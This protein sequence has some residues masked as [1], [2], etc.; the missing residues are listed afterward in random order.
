MHC[1]YPLLLGLGLLM[2]GLGARTV[3]A[4]SRLDATFG[5]NGRVAVELGVKS[6]G[7]AVLVQP[8]GKIVV[9]G[10]SSGAKSGGMNFSLVRF[11][12]DGSL[13]TTFN[14]EGSAV[15]PLVAG[16][17]EALALGL[18]SDGR[19]VVGGYS[20]NGLDRDFALA[21]YR[22]DGVLDR[23][24]GVEG[25]VLTSI[26]NGNEEITALA[27]N[28][29][30]Q[31]TAVGSTEGTA[32]KALAVVRYRAD[33]SLDSSFGEQG[34]SLLGVGGDANAEGL[35]ERDDGSLVISGSYQEKK[36]STAVLVGLRADG[37]IDAAFG[38]KG[39]SV[40]SGGFVASE[41]YRLAE[42]HD[43]MLY[44][45][46][47]VGPLG[48]RDAALFRFTRNGKPDPGFGKNGVVV[49]TISAADD[50]LYDVVAGPNGVA[51]SGF[52]IE[53]GGRQFLLA[54]YLPDGSVMAASGMGRSGVGAAV[55]EPAPIQEVRV[56]GRTRMQIRKLQL[57]NSDV[58]IRQ[59]QLSDSL[60]RSPPL[61]QAPPPE[62][63][64]LRAVRSTSPIGRLWGDFFCPGAWAADAA[65]ANHIA[66]V[67][68]SGIFTTAFSEGESVG[69]AL[70]A[71]ALGNVIV[72]GT[73]EGGGASSIVAARF[74]AD[75]PVDRIVDQPGHR[76]T[77]IT[78]TLSADVTRTTLTTG[79]EIDESFGETVVRR[80][81]VFSVR[82][83]PL[84]RDGVASATDS[85]LRRLA[86]FLVADAVA[87]DGSGSSTSASSPPGERVV[88]EGVTDNGG[89]NGVFNTL[90]EHLQPGAVYYIRAYALTADGAVYYGN[91]I[92]VRTADACFIA[93]ASFGSLLHPC[94]EIL[95]DF[96]DLYLVGHFG[97]QQLVEW[98]YTLSPPVADVVAG[99]AAL[100]F[101]VRLLL[102]PVI[103]FSWL[104]VQ[105]GLG[106]ALAALV[107]TAAVMSRCRRGRNM[108]F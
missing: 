97:G 100:R 33:G 106:A 58:Q 23:R 76:S 101:L 78:T 54:S 27:V 1:R 87:A 19:I 68:D 79:G 82:Q 36:N 70:T 2:I 37:M 108:R 107:A 75:D 55:G 4:F 13:D 85:G 99:N 89:G 20:H 91:Q 67:L 26:G 65:N 10:S 52:A 6:S 56:N 40:V 103:G 57:W 86:A 47:A 104:A 12:P 66:G 5:L 61:R 49:S 46:G 80:G 62:E 93:T 60:T 29:A 83:G 92:S 28:G 45:V 34:V 11:Q 71:D 105:G 48:K 59:M 84:Y 8:D 16:D 25:A 69:Y 98:Y 88:E 32:G 95:R 15:T 53:N 30:D 90:L 43:G 102:L 73:A 17:N 50:V 21:C 74:A 41:G 94:V 31:I 42:D 7:H 38:D 77:H 9:A 63:Q 96:R 51:A 22:S 3:C 44:L 39:I 81:V 72:V 64:G 18:L 14:G 35:V 24:F